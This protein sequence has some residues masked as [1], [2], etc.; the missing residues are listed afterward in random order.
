MGCLR[1]QP[2][3]SIAN[4]ATAATADTKPRLVTST[5]SW[6]SAAITSPSLA[7]IVTAAPII[8]TVTTMS[9]APSGPLT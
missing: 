4:P 7:G 9:V 1:M 8:P 2:W 3:F 5:G 6:I